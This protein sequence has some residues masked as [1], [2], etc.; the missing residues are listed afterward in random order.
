M[1]TK[2]KQVWPMA[3]RKDGSIGPGAGWPQVERHEKPVYRPPFWTL[4]AA[5]VVSAALWITTGALGMHLAHVAGW[6][7]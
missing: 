3:V 7:K 4:V 6:I 1:N 2:R 5:V